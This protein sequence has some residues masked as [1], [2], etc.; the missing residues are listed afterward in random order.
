MSY[1]KTAAGR[2]L[3][4]DPG[5]YYSKQHD[6]VYLVDLPQQQQPVVI[7]EKPWPKSVVFK[8][9]GSF[10]FLEPLP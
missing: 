10:E 1:C 7:V 5:L 3:V 4:P 6:E 8:A 9:D 2:R